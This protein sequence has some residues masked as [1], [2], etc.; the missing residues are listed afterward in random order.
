MKLLR[1][2]VMVRFSKKT[3]AAQI[4]LV[5]NG[6]GALKTKIPTITEYEWGVN[7]SPED[8]NLG[9][10]HCYLFTFKTAK[11]RDDYLINPVHLKL[12]KEVLSKYVSDLAVVDYWVK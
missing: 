8:V 3:T 10:T 9:F 2:F 11:D 12:K 1:H 4:K 5:N 7:N 6:L